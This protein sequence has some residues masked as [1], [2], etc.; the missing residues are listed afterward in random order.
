MREGTEILFPFFPA[1][2]RGFVLQEVFR[3]VEP[4]GRSIGQ[5]LKEQVFEPLDVDVFIGM[6]ENRQKE[7]NIADVDALS[8]KDVSNYLTHLKVQN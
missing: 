4:T 2:T 6:D 5:F 1:I 3:R 8:D 7:I